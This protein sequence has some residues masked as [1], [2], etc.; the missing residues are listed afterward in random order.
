MNGIVVV[1]VLVALGV[2]GLIF[3]APRYRVNRLR[4]QY[5]RGVHMPRAQAEESLARH[6]TRLQQ[7]YPDKSEAW[8]LRRILDDLHRDRR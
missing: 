3:W 6:L 7:R 8:Y 4:H 5:F 2:I 1:A